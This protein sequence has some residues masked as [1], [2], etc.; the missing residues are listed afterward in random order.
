MNQVTDQNAIQAKNDTLTWKLSKMSIA[1]WNG[2]IYRESIMSFANTDVAKVTCS[3][4][5]QS[6]I[7]DVLDI[8]GVAGVNKT[9]F[10]AFFDLTKGELEGHSSIVCVPT[11]W[12]ENRFLSMLPSGV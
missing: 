8:D 12:T 4:T 3:Y 10:R 6:K 5:L 2:L 11:L 9:E 1:E 7:G